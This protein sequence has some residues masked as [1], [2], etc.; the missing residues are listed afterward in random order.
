M[1][2]IICINLMIIKKISFQI[3]DAKQNIYCTFNLK[4][5][6]SLSFKNNNYRL[7]Q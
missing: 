1:T 4:I 7:N 2:S 5:L 6:N 3:P